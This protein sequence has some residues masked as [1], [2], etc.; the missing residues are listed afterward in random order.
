MIDDG[1]FNLAKESFSSSVTSQ[2]HF[3]GSFVSLA[4]GTSK[5]E[6]IEALG[7]KLKTN[8]FAWDD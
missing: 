5:S 8:C 7:T 6:G 1:A 4:C 3:Q 2:S